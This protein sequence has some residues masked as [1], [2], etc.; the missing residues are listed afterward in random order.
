VTD[1]SRFVVEIGVGT[2]VP[3][4]RPF[5]R[6]AAYIGLDVDL[7]LLTLGAARLI[8]GDA[9]RLPF[10]DRSVDHIVA[11]N[12]FGDIG[13]GFGFEEVVGL[14]PQRYAE[15]VQRLLARG[16]VD[17]L[18]ALRARVRTMSRSVDATKLSILREAARVLRR[19]GDLIVVETLT[20][21]FAQEWLTRLTPGRAD[22]SMLV[23]ENIEF[24][25]RAVAT[26]NRRRRYCVPSELSN[27]SLMVWVLNPGPAR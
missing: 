8:A 7:K 26:H 17:E 25:C 21:K 18:E 12:V 3:A 4:V 5:A 19:G 2:Q 16:A 20:P 15:H 24:Q 13:L 9:A 27:R 14:N 22:E 11:C 10:P 23:A 1:R 6:D